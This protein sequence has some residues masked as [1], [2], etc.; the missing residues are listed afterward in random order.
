MV[1]A[2]LLLALAAC[3]AREALHWPHAPLVR[4]IDGD[5]VVLR[6]A[7]VPAPWGPQVQVRLADIDAPE[8]RGTRGAE[9]DRAVAARDAL[10][11]RLRAARV[12]AVRGEGRDSFGRLVATLHADGQDAG[13]ALVVAGLATPEVRAAERRAALRRQGE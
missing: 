1:P 10:C 11:E 8:L 3:T 13:A 5:T 9:H 2:L 6:M 7:D 12:I 4:C